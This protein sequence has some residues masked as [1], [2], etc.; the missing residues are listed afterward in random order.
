MT[1]PRPI[2]IGNSFPLSLI[3]TKVVIDPCPVDI[4]RQELAHRPIHSFWGHRNT[5]TA[6][7]QLTGADLTPATERPALKLSPDFRPVLNELSFTECWVLS[8]DYTPGFRPPVNE[9]V[10]PEKINGWQVL[11]MVWNVL[12]SKQTHDEKGES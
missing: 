11:R 4:L 2:L 7:N 12:E 10:P 9:E 6:A 8:P 3:R 1:A 5:L